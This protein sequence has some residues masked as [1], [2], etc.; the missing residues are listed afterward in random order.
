[1][2]HKQETG[3]ERFYRVIVPKATSMGAAVVVLGALFKIQ[4]Y[5]GAGY[6]LMV[7]LGVES[8]IFLMG[9]FEPSPPPA[10]HYD[11]EKAYPELMSDDP[12]ELPVAK[13]KGGDAKL[14][15]G[16]LAGLDA[17]F[18]EL[19]LSTDSFKKFGQGIHA[20]NDTASKMKGMGDAV[21]A[22]TDYATNVKTASGSLVKLNSAYSKTVTAMSEMANVSSD[23]KAYHVQVQGITKNLGALNAVYEMELKDA[24]SHLKAMNK[25][26]GNL[27]SAMQNMSDVSK[28]SKVF[29]DQMGKLTT[30][31]TNLNKVYGNMLTAMKG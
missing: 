24:N 12:V 22:T 5:P 1:M 9:V 2:S 31:M 11:W 10:V 26:Y 30:N 16:V 19:N 8:L 7:G 15:T 13:N 25:F 17:M 6:M 23:A 29:K 21:N 28:E 20:L 4:H 27:T 3:P 18:G 14:S